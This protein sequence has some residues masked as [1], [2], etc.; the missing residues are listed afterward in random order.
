MRPPRTSWIFSLLALSTLPVR[1]LCGDVLST[2]GF[3]LCYDD[4]TI[5]I[6]AMS[7]TFD[8]TTSLVTYNIQGSSSQAQNVTAKVTVT[9]YGS[10]LYSKEFN[11]CDSGNYVEALCPVKAGAF[12]AQ[13]QETVPTSYSSEI[14]TIAFTVPDLEGAATV[15]LISNSDSSELACVQSTV[16]NGHSMNIAAATYAAAGI[17]GGALAVSA[18]GSVMGGM[19]TG[20][21]ATSPSF[22]EVFGWFQGIATNGMLSVKYPTIYQSF[23]KNFGFSTGLVSFASMQNSIDSFR[24]RT[25]G[26]LTDDNY[27][28]LQNATLVFSNGANS[29]SLKRRSLEH[30]ILTRDSINA[31]DAGNATTS[32]SQTITHYVKGMQAYVEQLSI[33]QANTFMTILLIVAIVVASI[34]CGIL[35]LKVILEAFS[36]RGNLSKPLESFRKRYWWRLAKTLTNLVLLLYGVWTLY[37]VYQFT[38]GD[39]WAAKLLAAVTWCIFTGVIAFFTIKIC[40]IV[41]RLRKMEGDETGLYDQKETW[42]KYSLFYDSFKKGYWWLFIPSIV[43]TFAKNAVVA[44]ANGNGLAQTI[45]QLVIE[46]C[47]LGLL[48]W[49]RPYTR[50]S[51][52]V[53]NIV[54]QVV[55]VISVIC[56]FVFVEELGITQT[57]KTVFGVVLIV[58][59]GILTAVLAILIAVNAVIALVKMNP[60]RRARKEAEKAN[61]DLDDLTPLDAR[62]SLLMESSMSTEYKG[63]VHAKAQMVSPSLH[64]TTS[65][66]SRYDPVS[67]KR[68]ESQEGYEMSQRHSQFNSNRNSSRRGFTRDETKEG[69][70]ES[71]AEMGSHERERSSSPPDYDRQHEARLPNV[72]LRSYR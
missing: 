42:I 49:N 57:T 17:A 61:R 13:G 36:L 46:V 2:D 40:L 19:H 65:K 30:L 5:Q 14:P 52:N 35:L 47:M 69:L 18:L 38:D 6:T 67:T 7:V 37:C 3:T 11:P 23:T 9:A 28:Y 56:V 60:H 66:D 68:P 45:G 70:I 54:I 48:A 25:G 62:N 1:V 21:G 16:T 50:K 41:R 64:T 33:P 27:Q 31:T 24:S 26:N 34:T 22:G 63:N 59:Q 12:S 53:I 44:G 39:S 55:R 10:D 51:S 72:E 4:P 15:Q 32:G 29:S 43:Y 8:R 58:I 20:V 71:A